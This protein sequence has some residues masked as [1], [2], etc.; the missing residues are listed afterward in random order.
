ME[1]HLFFSAW[2]VSETTP[3]N[4]PNLLNQDILANKWITQPITQP[5]TQPCTQLITQLI[6]QP[7]EYW[8]HNETSKTKAADEVA[9]L[10]EYQICSYRILPIQI[11]PGVR[12]QRLI[13]LL[14]IHSS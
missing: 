5:Y 6:T 9:F 14:F 12:Y 2:L 8:E 11:H 7:S 13:I 1:M 3:N 4:L 10:I